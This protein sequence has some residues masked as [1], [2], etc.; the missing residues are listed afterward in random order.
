[1]LRRRRRKRTR[2]R[3]VLKKAKRSKLVDENE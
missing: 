2:P 1:M 3:I